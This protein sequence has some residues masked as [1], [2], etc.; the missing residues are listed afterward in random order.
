MPSKTLAVT[1]HFETS[2][3]TGA[4]LAS[5]DYDGPVSVR[6]GPNGRVDHEGGVGAD[7]DVEFFPDREGSPAKARVV[8]CFHLLTPEEK[9]TLMI[10]SRQAAIEFVGGLEWETEQFFRDEGD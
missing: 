2:L 5:F 8:E 3:G 9:E 1:E 6:G 10:L 4:V 7:I